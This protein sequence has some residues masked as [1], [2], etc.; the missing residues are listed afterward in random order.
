MRAPKC[1][2]CRDFGV[3]VGSLPAL[4]VSA[5][6]RLLPCPKRCPAMRPDFAAHVVM[7]FAPIAAGIISLAKGA[8]V[9]A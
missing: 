5:P 1:S 8:G 7:V 3:I 2:V 6:L 4:P 9:L